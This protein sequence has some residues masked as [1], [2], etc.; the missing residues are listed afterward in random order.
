MILSHVAAVTSRLGLIATV[1]SSYDT[2]YNL[3]RRILSLDQVSR[4]RAAWNVVVTA[5]DDAARNFSLDQAL[6][7]DQRY[8]RAREFVEI[9]KALWASWEPGGVLADAESGRYIDPSKVHPIDY[10]GEHFK[11]RGPLATPRSPQGSPVIVQ[12]GGS[13]GGA[14]LAARFAHAVYSTQPEL[15]GARRYRAELKGRAQAYGR[16]PDT[17]KL[18]PGLVTV[19]GSTEAEA[20]A[21][22]DYLLSL[23]PAEAGVSLLSDYV[24]LPKEA[25]S[26]LDREL[27]WEIVPAESLQGVS[28]TPTLLRRAK[29]HKL[30]VRQLIAQMSAVTVHATAVGSPERIADKVQHWFEE[31]AVD[32]FNVMPAELPKGAADFVDHVLPILRRR[33]LFRHEYETTTLRGHYGL[34]V[35]D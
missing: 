26:E 7:K 8:A 32:G 11:V 27:P 35:D 13:E 6:S 29:E 16:D 14:D 1:S 12:A 22:S 30:T 21:R 5:G 18:L 2:P 10:V 20:K 17:I 34:G 23:I 28:H 33:G 9:V 19:V 4:G 24:R 3:A 15:E 31:G 25:L